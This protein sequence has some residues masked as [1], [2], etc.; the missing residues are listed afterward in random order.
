VPGSTG[1]NG[2]DAA[3]AGE[4]GGANAVATQTGSNGF[5]A[6]VLGLANLPSTSTAEGSLTSLGIGVGIAGVLLLL[7]RRRSGEE[8]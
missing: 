2:S 8:L 1:L 3:G 5:A 7:R 6:A 4:T